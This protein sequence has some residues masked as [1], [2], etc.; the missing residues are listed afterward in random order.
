MKPLPP[1]RVG[2]GWQLRCRRE[3]EVTAWQLRCRGKSRGRIEER[4]RR[5]VG[6][7]LSCLGKRVGRAGRMTR[8]VLHR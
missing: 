8:S 4:T 3:A 5:A 2:R 1:W 6:W 7:R